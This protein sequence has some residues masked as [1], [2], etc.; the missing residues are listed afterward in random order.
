M[1]DL[2]STLPALRASQPI[3]SADGV[4]VVMVCARDQRNVGIPDAK[5]LT[6]RIFN[7]RAELASRQL[8]R[9]LQRRAVINLRS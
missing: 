3:I 2:L 9:E 7:E 5:E 8:M 4:G 6:D 1:R